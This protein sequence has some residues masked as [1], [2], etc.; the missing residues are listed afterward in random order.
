[1][2]AQAT[3]STDMFA[4]LSMEEVIAYVRRRKPSIEIA[5]L[6]VLGKV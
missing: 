6:K 3:E 5:A 4:A 2:E 1:M